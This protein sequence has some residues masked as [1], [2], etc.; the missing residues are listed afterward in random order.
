MSLVFQ[1][2][3]LNVLIFAMDLFAHVVLADEINR[4]SPKVQSAML[5]A[6]ERRSLSTTAY[7]LDE[8]FCHS[9][10]KP[11][12][13]VGTYPLPTPQLD[14]FLLKSRWIILIGSGKVL[15]SIKEAFLGNKKINRD[16]VLA[17]N[18]LHTN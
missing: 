17:R 1:Y 13:L 4:T 11:L 15:D 5:E 10:S 6:W 7:P 18:Y 9:N 8:L 16:D 12:D 3:R 14:R 2:S